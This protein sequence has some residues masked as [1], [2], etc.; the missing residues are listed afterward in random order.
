MAKQKYSPLSAPTGSTKIGADEMLGKVK[1]KTFD[2]TRR[3]VRDEPTTDETTR[4]VH[5]IERAQKM[6]AAKMLY[7][8]RWWEFE[9]T[10]KMLDED[11][12]DDEKWRANL[13]DTMAYASIM[14]AQAAFIDSKVVPV[15]SKQQNDD[16]MRS[17]DLRDLYTSISKKGDLDNELY[18]AR[19][20]AF[21]L[22]T[23]FLFSYYEKDP[24][25]TW[26]IDSFN[27]ET[28]KITY[29]RKIINRFDDV[30]TIRVSPY[31]VLVDETCRSDFHGTAK[32]AILIEL[33]TRS[34]AKMKY[35]HLFGSPEVFDKRVPTTNAVRTISSG[36]IQNRCS[37]ATAN[38]N[39]RDVSA[40]IYTFF[41]PIELSG[42][43][44]GGLVEVLHYFC[45]KPEESYEILINGRPAQ[46]KTDTWP[47]P[48][49]WIHKEIPLTPIRWALYSGDEFW[50]RGIIEASRA[51]AK[52]SRE[53][54]EMMSD[55]QRI[56]LFSPV[57]T[58][59]TDEI[60]QRLLKLKPLSII[61]TRGGVPTQYKIPGITTADIQI[62]EDYHTSLKRS[63]GIDDQMI[64]G[65]NM[66]TL[67]TRRLTA[68]AIAFLRQS[69]FM[70]LKDFQFLYKQALLSEV[71]L[72][73]KLFEQYYDSPL[74]KSTNFRTSKD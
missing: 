67:G 45:V 6:K 9:R 46:V 59:V 15:I 31:L 55:R 4:A 60:D 12:P 51:D 30:K 5:I 36:D 22:G 63:T 65:G 14:T 7:S 69:L 27:P 8:S 42:G 11:R 28:D 52:A 73:L 17:S 57:F 18:L 70:R 50:G 38:T 20:D 58:D 66:G 39:T 49:P 19:L 43:N 74:K 61:R 54:R 72:K 33:I 53:H 64:G 35:G 1:K 13:P 68:T 71:R 62:A 24:R 2:S 40:H 29:T 56:S 41:A 26:E 32:D 34:E 10:W 37:A 47:C 23:G 25:I 21:K 3:P 44:E 48:L 16:M